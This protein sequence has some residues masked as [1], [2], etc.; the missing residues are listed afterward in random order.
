[1]GSLRVALFVARIPPAAAMRALQRH[2]ACLSGPECVPEHMPDNR[3]THARKARCVRRIAAKPFL[4]G[5]SC[6]SATLFD[7]DKT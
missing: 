7:P 4:A 1:M 6:L 5:V 3:K 2:A